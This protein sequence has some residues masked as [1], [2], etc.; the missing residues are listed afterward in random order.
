MTALY[1]AFYD[2]DFGA[3][4]E[5]NTFYTPFVIGST[6]EEA[7]DLAKR[8]IGSLAKVDLLD[9]YEDDEITTDM[10]ET[11]CKDWSIHIVRQELGVVNN[12]QETKT[13]VVEPVTIALNGRGSFSHVED[14]IKEL[15][16][17]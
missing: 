3:S 4:E 9:E 5:W 2:R 12:Y 1:V 17:K 16:G 13:D 15:V 7:T 11:A 6:E 14:I 10:I 8:S